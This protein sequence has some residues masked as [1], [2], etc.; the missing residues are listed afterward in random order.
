MLTVESY[1]SGIV[2]FVPD[3]GGPEC[4]STSP[5]CKGTGIEASGVV[6]DV[7]P[8]GTTVQVIDE[9]GNTV[10]FTGAA[11]TAGQGATVTATECDFTMIPGDTNTTEDGQQIYSPIV[12]QQG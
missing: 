7:V 9:D 12:I 3:P 10:S 4:P 5:S 8:Y 1:A 2:N 6:V 11:C